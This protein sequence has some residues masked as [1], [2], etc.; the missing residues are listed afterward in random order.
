MNVVRIIAG[1]LRTAPL[2]GALVALCAIAGGALALAT[3]SVLAGAI[4]A[5]VHGNALGSQLLLLAV[6]LIAETVIGAGAGIAGAGFRTTVA[7][8]IRL[9][10]VDRVLMLGTEGKRQFGTG[11]LVS[12]LTGDAPSAAELLPGLASTIVTVATAVGALV[13]IA[14]IDIRLLATI[15]LGLPILI[16][17]VRRFIVQTGGVLERY[18]RLQAAIATRLLDAHGGARTIHASATAAQEVERVLRPLPELS[19]AG[20][21]L[22]T[23]QRGLAVRAAILV[24]L[25]EALV[26]AVAGVSVVNDRVTPGQMLAAVA[27]LHLALGALDQLDGLI[28]ALKSRIGASRTAEVLDTQ[29]AVRQSAGAGSLPMGAGALSLCGVSVRSGG[30]LVLEGL[31]LDVPAG[32]S[33]ALVG[34]SGSGKSTLASLAGRLAD[35]DRGTVRIDGVDIRNVRLADVRRAV[36]YAFERP[37]LL[38]EDL[39]ALI[40]YGRPGS[41]RSEVEAAARTAQADGFIRRLPNAYATAPSGAP[42]SGGE[43]QRLGLAQAVLQDARLVVLDDATSSLDTA[44]EVRVAEAFERALKGRTSLVVAHRATTAARADLV[45][46]LEDG[47]VR[48][49]APHAE[50]WHAA[51]YRSVFSAP[52]CDETHERAA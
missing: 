17:L 38:G 10:F 23:C 2:P 31:D 44:T 50:L 8:Q 45:A 16:I 33:V 3:P 30:R 7:A 20:R 37:A 48:A 22:W 35:P 19:A 51:D 39:H 12:R 28:H 9:R 41:T 11:G 4:D 1:T 14:L 13:G 5:A 34:R 42:L 29:P 27:Y 24:P 49:L 15:A 40:A 46:W 21:E 6:L 36:A 52:A 25:L 18:A 26:L 43:R 32:L 47:R